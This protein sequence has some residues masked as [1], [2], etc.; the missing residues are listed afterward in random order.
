MYMNRDETATSC[1][2]LEADFNTTNQTQRRQCLEQ[3]WS[4]PFLSPPDPN[5]RR[6][7]YYSSYSKVPTES[8]RYASSRMQENGKSVYFISSHVAT[9][10]LSPPWQQRELGR[11]ELTRK[12]REGKE[13]KAKHENH[14]SIIST[15]DPQSR[16]SLLISFP[17]WKGYIESYRA[18]DRLRCMQLVGNSYLKMGPHGQ[19]KVC[20]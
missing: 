9:T 6:D 7:R 4:F 10:T 20:A 11:T 3:A 12:E 1:N 5:N 17:L 19:A 18:S 14:L 2:P 16:L 8:G 15:R 13:R